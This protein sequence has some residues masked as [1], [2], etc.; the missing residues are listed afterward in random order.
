M[1]FSSS[2]LALP[3]LMAHADVRGE[4]FSASRRRRACKTLD[5][6]IQDNDK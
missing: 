6:R 3:R 4:A 2:G 1:L 5:I